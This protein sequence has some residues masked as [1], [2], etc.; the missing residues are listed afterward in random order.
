KVSTFK[1]QFHYD[2]DWKDI[3]EFQFM[4]GQEV[5]HN[6]SSGKSYSSRYFPEN[7]TGEKAFD[8]IALGTVFESSSSAGSPVRIS[9]FIGRAYY[10]YDDRYLVTLAMRA[11]GSTKFAPGNQWGLFPAVS[12]AWRVMNEEF[13]QEVDYLSN[14]KVRI[15][16]GIS[17]NDRI[18]S[19]LFAKYYRVNRNRPVG[20][21]EEMDHYYYNF[22][23]TNN[24][25][26]PT[27]RWETTISRNAG[28]DFGFFNEKINGTVDVYWNTVKDLLV[29]SDIPAHSGYTKIMTNVG[30]T[31]NR[32][33]DV[34]LN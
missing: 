5:R 6:A 23:D 27:V 2:F 32:G 16:Y 7:I 30:Q 11:D 9:S 24:L 14:L 21:G 13:M 4:I 28:L 33:V 17:G 12:A 31:S 18:G 26:N 20:W 29:P 8:N 10:G 1:L 22:F 15:G 19:D 3:H 34:A 25:Y